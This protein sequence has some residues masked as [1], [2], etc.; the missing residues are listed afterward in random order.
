MHSH[1]N[2]GIQV[3]LFCLVVTVVEV[4]RDGVGSSLLFFLTFACA[5]DIELFGQ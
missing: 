4:P 1:E 3:H 2:E 5:N